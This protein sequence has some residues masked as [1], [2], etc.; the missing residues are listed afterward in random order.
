LGDSVLSVYH[1]DTPEPEQLVFKFDENSEW[2]LMRRIPTA[3][4]SSAAVALPDGTLFLESA[5]RI[6]GF[7]PDGTEEVVWEETDDKTVRMHGGVELFVG[8]L[9]P[10]AIVQ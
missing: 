9:D 1:R 7:M 4:I 6:I 10:G 5:E 8:P 2:T 3:L